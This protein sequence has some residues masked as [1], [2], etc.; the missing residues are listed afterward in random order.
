[1]GRT[2][3]NHILVINVILV[4]SYDNKCLFCYKLKQL[5]VYVRFQA[6]SSM[7]ITI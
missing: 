1:V 3:L 2:V 7:D 6:F 4:T 5:L